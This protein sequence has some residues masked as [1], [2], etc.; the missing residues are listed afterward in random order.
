MLISR[1]KKDRYDCFVTDILHVWT[2]LRVTS[3]SVSEKVNRKSL[4][5]SG[6]RKCCVIY[7]KFAK[8]IIAKVVSESRV[9]VNVAL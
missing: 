5:L 8:D 2:Q 3:L 6:K 7:E 4:F 9:I 1:A